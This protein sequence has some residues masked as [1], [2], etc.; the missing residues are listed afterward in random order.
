MGNAIAIRPTGH[1]SEKKSRTL[2]EI[3]L[4]LLALMCFYP[5][6]EENHLLFAGAALF[7]VLLIL[8]VTSPHGRPEKVLSIEELVKHAQGEANLGHEIL[9]EKYYCQAIYRLLIS[10]RKME[11]AGIFEQYF[12]RYRRVFAPRIQLEICRELCQSGKY[13]TAARAL[14]KVIEDWTGSYR[15]SDRKFLEQAYLH[16]ARI[17]AEKLELPALAAGCY[18][19]FLDQFPRSAYRET[20]LYQL[21]VLDQEVRLA[22]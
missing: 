5:F 18:F 14:E 9:A 19:A 3:A 16:L 2:E 8:A 4:A 21:Q 15:H 20:A 22:V 6:T 12:V 13:L 11:A 1:H 7:M 17:Y 10:D